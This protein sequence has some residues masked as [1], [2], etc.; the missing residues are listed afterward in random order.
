M[1]PA[2]TRHH[3]I[4]CRGILHYRPSRLVHGSLLK[5]GGQVYL[6]PECYILSSLFGSERGAGV[7]MFV[8]SFAQIALCSCAACPA[9]VWRAVTGTVSSLLSEPTGGFPLF[10]ASLASSSFIFSNPLSAICWLRSTV[11]VA[12][13]RP[14][15]TP[16]AAPLRSPASLVVGLACGCV[17]GSGERYGVVLDYW[18]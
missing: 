15:A 4:C 14:P 16:C 1:K 9:F 5:S 2:S 12:A 10:A 3:I 17:A 6:P 11:P 8:L 13:C 18:W 7:A